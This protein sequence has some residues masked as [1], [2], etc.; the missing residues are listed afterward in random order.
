MAP[1]HVY[2]CPAPQLVSL[3]CTALE[4]LTRGCSKNW[5]YEIEPLLKSLFKQ[6]CYEIQSRIKIQIIVRDI[7]L[8]N[9]YQAKDKDFYTRSG[10][11]NMLDRNRRIKRCPERFQDA[12]EQFD[13]IITCQEKVFE[14]VL[15]GAFDHKHPHLKAQISSIQQFFSICNFDPP[16]STDLYSR[17]S[18][19]SKPV[20]IVNVEIPDTHEDATLGA[21]LIHDVVQQ[22]QYHMVLGT[23]RYF[24]CQLCIK[25]LNFG[26]WI[27]K[28]KIMKQSWFLNCNIS[29]L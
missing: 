2:V 13:V 29:D 9:H 19:C 10:L 24:G 23:W 22:V 6:S 18:M 7:L 26:G 20:L 5:R 3:M 14:Q 8:F 16:S 1:V 17:D 21:F 25:L 15:E 11:L 28:S 27:S 12:K 4:T